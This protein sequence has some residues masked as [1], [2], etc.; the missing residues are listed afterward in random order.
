MILIDKNGVKYRAIKKNNEY[1]LI[2]EYR[3]TDTK[4]IEVKGKQNV[5]TYIKN[6]KLKKYDDTKDKEK[7]KEEEIRREL[8]EVSWWI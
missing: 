2:I 3:D 8:R 5:L 1:Y 6:N 7:K 4:K